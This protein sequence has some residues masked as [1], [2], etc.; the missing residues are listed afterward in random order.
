MA[1]LV[2][3]E[4]KPKLRISKP[5]LVAE[6]VAIEEVLEKVIEVN[7]DDV[8]TTETIKEIIVVF[9]APAETTQEGD[10]EQGRNRFRSFIPMGKALRIILDQN[11]R[12]ILI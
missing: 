3:K 4:E 6:V 2:E 9:L 12:S 10:S 7:E 5:L 8:E 1:S 11:V